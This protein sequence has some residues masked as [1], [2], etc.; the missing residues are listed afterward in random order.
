MSFIDRHAA[1]LIYSTD[2]QIQGYYKR[3]SEC[4]KNK[5]SARTV[6]LKLNTSGGRVQVHLEKDDR[7]YWEFHKYGS[8][9]ST[10][11][12]RGKGSQW[13]KIPR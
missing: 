9:G 13:G 10:L 11:F 3:Y 1:F 7:G 5:S 12:A 6:Y 4:S 2:K 8:S